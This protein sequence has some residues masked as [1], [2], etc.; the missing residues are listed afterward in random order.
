MNSLILLILITFLMILPVTCPKNTTPEKEPG[1]SNRSEVKL[2]DRFT[3]KI[4]RTDIIIGAVLLAAI[5]L[6]PLVSAGPGE[7]EQVIQKNDTAGHL[8]VDVIAIDPSVKNATPYYQ[9]LMMSAEGKENQLNDLD[10]GIDF[11]YPHDPQKDVLKTEL[12][13]KMKE[14]WD[15]YPVIFEIT[16]GGPDYPAYGGSIF[17]VKFASSFQNITLTEEENNVIRKSAYILNESDS[18]KK[19]LYDPLA[20]SVLSE[21]PRSAPAGH[22]PVPLSPLT[23]CAAMAC[24]GMVCI[25][26]KRVRQQR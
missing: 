4:L 21:S 18:R 19:H 8:L 10:T 26:Q 24:A 5:V 17:T 20:A 7:A 2:R 3:M 13:E 1:R 6:V 23:A 25:I 15:K 16:P 9:F 11:L 22:Q 14:I 12:R